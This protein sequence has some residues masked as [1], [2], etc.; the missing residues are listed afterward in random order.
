M[1]TTRTILLFSLLLSVTAA[2]AGRSE[3]EIGMQKLA[4]SLVGNYQ[5]D[6][7]VTSDLKVAI[8]KFNA[9]EEL[10]KKNIGFAVSELLTHSLAAKPGFIVVE[11]LGL[12][13]ILTELNI[14]M[15]GAVD[16]DDALEAGKL[17]GAKYLVLGSVEK[18]GARYHVNARFVEVETGRIHSTAYES[19]PV[20]IFEEEAENYLAYAPE[21]Q[22]IGLYA[23]SNMRHNT[24]SLAGQDFLFNN[25]PSNSINMTKELEPA[26]VNSL[27]WG[28][29]LRYAPVKRL[30][31][32]ISAMS[33]GAR[34]KA[35]H[36]RETLTYLPP[37][38]TAP[39]AVSQYNYTIRISAYRGLI[40]GKT[41]IYDGLFGYIGSGIAVY[42]ISGGAE[43]SYLTP[44]IQLRAEYFLQER[45]GLSLSGS[46]D[47]IAKTAKRA[48]PDGI[49]KSNRFRL[50]KF[51][52]EPT[53]SLYF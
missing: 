41:I 10:Q 4:D 34:Q 1:T 50:D 44:F 3:I 49:T 13:K 45:V 48:E 46:Y 22:R 38:Y 23:L 19:F 20:N 43:A 11:R 8:F 39:Q 35:G 30:L 33:T 2:F 32:D 18:I 36:I 5:K 24:N 40:S 27:C 53:I 15:S 42:R 28:F 37:T 25:Y 12:D 52:F 9:S 31:V 26:A 51:Y 16:P 47:F 7:S 17:G 14:N 21:T 29:G 6:H